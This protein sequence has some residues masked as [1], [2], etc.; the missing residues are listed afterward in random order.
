MDR[1]VLTESQLLEAMAT[2]LRT[3]P[4]ETG[5]HTAVELVTLTNW[6]LSRVHRTLKAL[7]L[8]GRLDVVKVYRPEITGTVRRVAGYRL[9]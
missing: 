1:I 3:Q 5:A 4:D 9:R 7:A 8:E 6:P 2:A